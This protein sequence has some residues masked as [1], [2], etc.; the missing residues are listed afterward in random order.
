[1]V[2]H[3]P[4]PPRGRFVLEHID[5]LVFSPFNNFFNHFIR[6]SSIAI[7]YPKFLSSCII[8]SFF[9][10]Y[11]FYISAKHHYLMF[12]F[13]KYFLIDSFETLNPNNFIFILYYFKLTESFFQIVISNFLTSGLFTFWW[14]FLEIG[15][16][17]VQHIKMSVRI[18]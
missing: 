6:I 12:L 10:V 9:S 5:N 1:M 17:Y 8:Q 2:Q 15:F 16:L 14:L 3:K 7:S 18:E 13:I 4:P 11:Y